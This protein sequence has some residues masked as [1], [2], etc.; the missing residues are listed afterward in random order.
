M[1]LKR[2]FTL[3]S[4]QPLIEN[5]FC[6]C[7]DISPKF[8]I[9]C[10]YPSP[11]LLFQSMTSTSSIISFN[12]SAFERFVWNKGGAF[13]HSDRF[14]S[15]FRDHLYPHV[16]HVNFFIILFLLLFFFSAFTFLASGTG[17]CKVLPNLV[18]GVGVSAAVVAVV[19][20]EGMFKLLFLS[21]KSLMCSK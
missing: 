7:E 21:L 16:P 2:F 18:L 9:S 11:S 12:V 1:L 15:S 10:G 14:C 8:F 17:G 5:C 3:C 19:G 13:S 20:S 4:T 6:W